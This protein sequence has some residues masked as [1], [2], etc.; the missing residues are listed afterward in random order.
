MAGAPSGLPAG[1]RLSDH[2]SLGVIA[3]TFSIE[4]VRRVLAETGRASERERDLPAHVMVYYCR[5]YKV[6]DT[7]GEFGQAARPAC[8]RRPGPPRT[9]G[10]EPDLRDGAHLCRRP[11]RPRDAQLPPAR[12]FANGIRPF[13]RRSALALM[14]IITSNGWIFQPEAVPTVEI[15]PSHTT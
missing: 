7:V 10:I 5:A 12:D 11:D 6:T 13:L 4:E 8:A 14:R 3:R 15:R 9:D 1:I 2:I